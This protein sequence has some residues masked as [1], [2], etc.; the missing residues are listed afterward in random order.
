[1]N[2]FNELREASAKGLKRMSEATVKAAKALKQSA[3]STRNFARELIR[4][5]E[6]EE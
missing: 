4:I 5:R 6:T 3:L 1:M 2:E